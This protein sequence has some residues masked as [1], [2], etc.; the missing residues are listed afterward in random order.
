MLPYLAADS[1]SPK[2]HM[3]PMLVS[4]MGLLANMERQNIA[5]GTRQG[6]ETAKAEGKRMGRLLKLN[7][8][9]RANRNCSD[10]R[11]GE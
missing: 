2:W 3:D 4:L 11:G 6:L 7:E 1:D 5:R 10:L 8:R 9:D